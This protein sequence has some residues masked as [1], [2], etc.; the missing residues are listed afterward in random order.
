MKMSY[1]VITIAFS[2]Q[3]TSDIKVKTEVATILTELVDSVIDCK[4]IIWC[5]CLI[6]YI[7]SF[8]CLTA[9]AASLPDTSDI[10]LTTILGC[11]SEYALA[12]I[13]FRTS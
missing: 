3:T 4:N 8:S 11:F 7:P 2:V 6:K 5:V 1:T 10:F 13:K 12:D 9:D